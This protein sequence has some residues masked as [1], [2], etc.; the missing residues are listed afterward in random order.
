[1]GTVV[2]PGVVMGSPNSVLP[3]RN[4]PSVVVPGDDGPLTR[5]PQTLSQSPLHIST[6]H[7]MN[8]SITSGNLKACTKA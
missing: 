3:V 4:G 8:T 5:E 6:L 7:D 2:G 1:M